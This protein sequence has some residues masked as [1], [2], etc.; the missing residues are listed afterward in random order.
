MNNHVYS[1]KFLDGPIDDMRN[2]NF[3]VYENSYYFHIL[4]LFDIVAAIKVF[5]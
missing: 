1:F 2:V 4:G 3:R 5:Y